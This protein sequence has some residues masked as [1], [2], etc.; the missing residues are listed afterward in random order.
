[1]GRGDEG[2][3]RQSAVA[4]YNA[5]NNS[6][7]SWTWMTCRPYVGKFKRRRDEGMRWTLQRNHNKSQ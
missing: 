4:A 1:M 2:V 5:W 6:P 3:G 7:S